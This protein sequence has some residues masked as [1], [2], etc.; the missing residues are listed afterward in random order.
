MNRQ[1]LSISTENT[2]LPGLT[3]VSRDQQEIRGH[4][5]P[6]IFLK[7]LLSP[8]IIPCSPFRRRQTYK[9]G[10]SPHPLAKNELD[11]YHLLHRNTLQ[12]IT[13][14]QVCGIWPQNMDFIFLLPISRLPTGCTGNQP[15]S[16]SNSYEYEPEGK[17]LYPY[18]AD[19][20]IFSLL[21]PID[22][23]VISLSHHGN[24]L[25]KPVVSTWNAQPIQTVFTGV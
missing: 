7:F 3:R 24:V 21:Q 25:T 1:N 2:T 20:A 8:R 19:L 9:C 23:A 18:A 5:C 17:L 10:S 6:R 12:K 16:H 11:H 22:K 15:S 13:M 14:R 4:F